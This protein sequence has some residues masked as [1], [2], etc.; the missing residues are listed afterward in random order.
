MKRAMRAFA[1]RAGAGGGVGGEFPG[2]VHALSPK[3]NQWYS[4]LMLL[5][6]QSHG[7]I[8]CKH[9]GAGGCSGSCNGAQVK[10]VKV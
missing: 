10:R 2:G 5:K 6:E 3:I 4:L 1:G 8:Y 7:K 9:M